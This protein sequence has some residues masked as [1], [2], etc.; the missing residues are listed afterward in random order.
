MGGV[1]VPGPAGIRWCAVRVQGPTPVALDNRRNYCAEEVCVLDLGFRGS[2]SFDGESCFVN[3]KPSNPL[4]LDEESRLETLRLKV[5]SAL[6]AARGTT[7]H[8][9]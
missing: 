9:S 6:E 8:R 2:S 3:S 4:G 5:P 7:P 1:G